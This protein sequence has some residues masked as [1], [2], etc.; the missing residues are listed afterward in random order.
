MIISLSIIWVTCFTRAVKLS[1]RASQI[2]SRIGPVCEAASIAVLRKLDY[3]T[4]RV[5]PTVLQHYLVHGIE[6]S[7]LALLLSVELHRDFLTSMLSEV[8][9]NTPIPAFSVADE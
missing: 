4:S 9:L 8:C 7:V 5:G 3:M 6:P 1:V 2:M